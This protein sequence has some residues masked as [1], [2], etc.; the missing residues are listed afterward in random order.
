MT[1]SLS[2]YLSFCA[3][4]F[5]VFIMSTSISSGSLWSCVSLSMSLCLCLLTFLTVSLSLCSSAVSKTLQLA[6]EPG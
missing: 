1:A 2:H 3:Q 6:T 4:L 5:L